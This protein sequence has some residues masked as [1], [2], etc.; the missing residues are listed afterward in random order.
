MDGHLT[1]WRPD[2]LAIPEKDRH[3]DM[4]MLKRY[5]AGSILT[6]SDKTA[7]ELWDRRGAPVM[8]D[9]RKSD[10]SGDPSVPTE[11]VPP[12]KSTKDL[13]TEVQRAPNAPEIARTEAPEETM[14]VAAAQAWLS[15]IDGGE[16]SR[17]WKEA[18]EF[19]R[20]A[21][22]EES[23]VGSMKTFRKP[24]GHAISRTL[25]SAQPTKSLPG[26]PDGDYVVMQFHASFSGKKAAVE[27][28]TF[29]QETDGTWKASGYF[30]K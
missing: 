10:T 12:M 27:T 8:E 21:V 15:T 5:G 26:A 6:A 22:T 20:S 11:G 19:F 29:T 23:W 7:E 24:L 3:W 9:D 1:L 30:L 25:K 14:A 13:K 28:V 2:A 17:S 4:R 18:A 16:Y